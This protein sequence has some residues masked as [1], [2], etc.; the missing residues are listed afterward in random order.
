MIKTLR[1]L[2]LGVAHEASDRV[3][4]QE[5]KP[6][7]DILSLRGALIYILI[8]PLNI[9][10]VEHGAVRGSDISLVEEIEDLASVEVRVASWNAINADGAFRNP[11]KVHAEVHH[12]LSG[13]EVLEV[14]AFI[15]EEVAFSPLFC[16]KSKHVNFRLLREELGCNKLVF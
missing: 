8:E 15:V 6:V 13:S 4:S 3:F 9:Q 11:H 7:H 2:K 5:A 14:G 16:S 1:G 12:A 10:G